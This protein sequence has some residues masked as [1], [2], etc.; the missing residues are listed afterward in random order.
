MKGKLSKDA[1][2]KWRREVS[3]KQCLILNITL[4]VCLFVIMMMK[5]RRR[6]GEIAIRSIGVGT[7]G[8]RSIIIIVICHL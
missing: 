1:F 7:I 3:F 2:L 4:F 6:V 8:A 5:E